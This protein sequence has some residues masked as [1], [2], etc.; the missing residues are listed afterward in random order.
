MK[1]DDFDK[2]K[3]G[4]AVFHRLGRTPM[5]LLFKE[6]VKVKC[7]YMDRNGILLESVFFD[8]E[9]L[10]LNDSSNYPSVDLLVSE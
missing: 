3:E 1:K 4:D 5:I 7:R 2:L 6:G 10:D 9:L 8:F